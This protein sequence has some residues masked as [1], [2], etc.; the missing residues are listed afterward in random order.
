M[1]LDA[2]GRVK[3]HSGFVSRIKSVAQTFGNDFVG[4]EMVRKAD[5]LL[6]FRHIDMQRRHD[7]KMRCDRHSRGKRSDLQI[8][9]SLNH[10]SFDNDH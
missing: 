8:M 7:H 1:G 10:I 5:Q 6:F 2:S 9:C 4:N 3:Y